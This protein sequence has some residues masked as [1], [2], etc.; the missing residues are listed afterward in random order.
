MDENHDG[1]ISEKE[2]IEVKK[3]VELK[4]SMKYLKACLSHKKFS[5]MLALKIIDVFVADEH[6]M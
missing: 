6:Q 4:K 2:F 1:G 5:T 3:N